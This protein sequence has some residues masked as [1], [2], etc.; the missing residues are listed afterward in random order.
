MKRLPSFA[1]E[2][3]ETWADNRLYLEFQNRQQVD[4][5][6]QRKHPEQYAICNF[7]I[8]PLNLCIFWHFVIPLLF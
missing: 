3:A 4:S 1:E 6:K 8:L 7:T 2:T 5:M